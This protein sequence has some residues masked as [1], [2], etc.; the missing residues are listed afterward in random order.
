MSTSPITLGDVRAGDPQAY[1]DALREESA[2]RRCTCQLA[3]ARRTG[4]TGNVSLISPVDFDPD[5]ELHAPFVIEDP[6]MRAAAFRW[7]LAGYSTGYE[8]ATRTL[9]EA[10]Q[11]GYSTGYE[12]AS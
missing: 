3:A 11:A 10:L 12:P 2:G 9:T 4:S 7:W 8:T 5:C 1:D 6:E